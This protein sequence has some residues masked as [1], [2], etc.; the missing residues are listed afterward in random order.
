V[1]RQR[2]PRG[3]P[4]RERHVSSSWPPREG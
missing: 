2:P 4:P 3:A 1:S